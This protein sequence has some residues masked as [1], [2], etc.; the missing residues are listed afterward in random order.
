MSTLTPYLTHWGLAE[1]PVPAGA[2]P[3]LRVRA[4]RPPG[5]PGPDPVRHHAARRAGGDHGRD[6]LR[7]RPCSPRPCARP[8][9]ARA[10]AW[11]RS[12][13]RRAPPRRCCRPCCPRWAPTGRG[14]GRPPRRAAS[15]RG[16]QE[17]E[18]EGRRVVIAIDEAQRL[19][20]RALEEV[21]LLTNPGADGPG[22]P[23]VLL[24]QPEL[25]VHIARHPQVAQRVVVRYHLGNMGADEVDAYALHRTRVAGASKR[26]ISKKASKAVYEET[27]R[28]AA[29][30]QPAAGQRPVRG[31]RAA[32]TRRW[33]RTSSATWPRTAARASGRAA[34]G[35]GRD[36][37]RVS[38]Q[39]ALGASGPEAAAVYVRL[40][41][42]AISTRRKAARHEITVSSPRRQR[43]W[44]KDAV[45]LSGAGRR[46]GRR[47]AG[48][49]G[50]GHGA[51]DRLAGRG[52]RRR[53]ARRR[54]ASR[55][56]VRRPRPSTA[57]GA[58]PGM[59]RG[60]SRGVALPRRRRAGHPHPLAGD[61][62]LPRRHAARSRT[63]R[64]CTR[65]GSPRGACAPRWT[66]STTPSRAKSFRPLLRQVKEITD[67]L[68]D[69]RDLDVAVE[70]LLGSCRD[71][72]RGRAPGH[73]GPHRPLPRASAPPRT[74]RSPRCSRGSTRR[75]FEAAPERLHRQAHRRGVARLK[76]AAAGGLSRWPSPAR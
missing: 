59:S 5:G 63:S 28:R 20:P 46:R 70:R 37:R 13:T 44:L 4:G 7:A 42:E 55:C 62:E 38:Y 22:A 14:L 31:G 40:G 49:G 32:A 12:P 64:S 10:S 27:E 50:P 68:G 25:T 30:G 43:R 71:D 11:P 15:A 48:A 74:P 41:D 39:A 56:M 67:V 61:D 24:G 69:A 60:C 51:R 52:Q 16:W 35:G 72:G 26:I 75:R 1:A 29:A 21:R 19:D 17:P 47:P 6:R 23:V 73:R 66:R 53:A 8:S 76:P 9:T 33:A 45:A 2:G 34:R 65:C 57:C 36:V 54:C 58:T 18:A 3:A